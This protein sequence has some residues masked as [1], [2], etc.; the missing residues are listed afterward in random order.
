VKV[1][2]RSTLFE[3]RQRVELKRAGVESSLVTVDIKCKKAATVK[4][5]MAPS[6]R[7]RLRV[8]YLICLSYHLCS[9]CLKTYTVWCEFVVQ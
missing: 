9:V 5:C 8:D 2:K 1:G 7:C 6:P 4:M 3:S